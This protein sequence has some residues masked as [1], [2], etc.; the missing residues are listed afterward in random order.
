MSNFLCKLEKWER[1]RHRR[2]GSLGTP[3]IEVIK[4]TKV[5]KNTTTNKS[6]ILFYYLEPTDSL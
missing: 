6:D 2:A 3:F 4:R 1:E 5:H